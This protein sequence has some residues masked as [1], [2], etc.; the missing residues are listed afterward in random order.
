KGHGALID[1]LE[2]EC[3][4]NG[5]AI[6]LGAAIIAIDEARGG[7]VA[8]C[9]D[10]TVF[11]ADAAIITV[12]LPL[13]A[14]IALP[15]AARERTAAI[16]DIGFGNVVKILL[17]FTTKWWADHGGRDLADLS[18]LVSDAQ[19]PTWWTQHPGGRP[20]L[21]GWFAGPKADRVSSLTEADLVDMGL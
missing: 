2:A 6:E 17:G 21:T 14:E 15:P 12:P 16:P 11:E 1:Y 19:V 7:I 18:F 13:L 20:V 8:R 3:L 10:G 5:A 4:R 9:R